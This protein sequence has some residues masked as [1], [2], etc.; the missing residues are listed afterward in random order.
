[1]FELGNLCMRSYDGDG[2]L[3]DETTILTLEQDAD[4]PLQPRL[5]NGRPVWELGVYFSLCF[6]PF[7]KDDPSPDGRDGYWAIGDL[8]P[9]WVCGRHLLLLRYYSQS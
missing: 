8:M 1:M 3:K 5:F 6:T 7:S 9:P 2:K 4:N